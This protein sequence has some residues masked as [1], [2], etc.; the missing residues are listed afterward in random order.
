[1]KKYIFGSMAFVLGLYI[2]SK[3]NTKPLVNMT[4]ITDQ[5][6]VVKKDKERNNRKEIKQS[7]EKEEKEE[8]STF[9]LAS[10]C[11]NIINKKIKNKSFSPRIAIIL[12]SGMG[13]VAKSIKN[14]IYIP[15]GDLPGF[16]NSTVHGHAGN[17][18][19]GSIDGI[20]VACLQGRVHYYE[21]GPASAVMVPIN[22]LKMLGCDILLATAAVGSLN[23][24]GP[25][26]IVVVKDHINFQGVNPL[27]G[28]NEDILGPRF[29]SLQNAYDKELRTLLHEA[30]DNIK[31]KKMTEG[32]YCSLLGPS[33]ETPAEV[34]MIWNFGADIVGMSLVGEIIAARHCGMKC[35]A[36]AIVVNFAEGLSDTKITHEETLHY[37]DKVA[38]SVANLTKEYIKLVNGKII[39]NVEAVEAVEALEG[40]EGEGG[41]EAVEGVESVDDVDTKE[42][43][44]NIHY[45]H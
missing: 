28:L 26:S 45:Y 30:S 35:S 14:A 5:I 10:S 1:M 9:K 13:N 29:P 44:N 24:I 19:L 12:G 36:L 38:D 37:T 6:N 43:R 11:V 7:G 15:Y 41:V 8:K 32:V 21:G 16:S 22:T 17:V 31:M 2:Y 34:N 40:V 27:V 20:D 3:K 18:V 25:G 42:E 33:F 4:K 23:D 39:D